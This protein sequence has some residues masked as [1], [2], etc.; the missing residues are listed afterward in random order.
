MSARQRVDQ[1]PGFVLH[2]YPYRET[3]LIVEVFSRDFGRI[4][5]VAKGARRPM[6]QLRGVL[7][8]FQ[9]LLID[10]SGGGEMKTLVRAEW[11]G[12]QPLLGGQ[13]LLCAYY[14]NELLM[15]LMPREDSHPE[16]HRAY[17]EA[18]RALAANESQEVVLRRFELA[19]LQE[20]GYGLCLDADADGVPVR[21]D[22]HYAYIIERGAVSLDEY[23]IDDPS[24]VSG[25]TLLD[26][27]C[28]DFRDPE[29]LA[30]SKAL[31]RR[32]IQH[33]LGGQVLQSR[34]VFTELFAFPGDPS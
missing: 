23:G 8:A 34:R 29:A 26:M 33:Y 25:K 19:L 32:L 12:G 30:Q 15:R 16:L 24:V 5:L 2:S 10:W 3:S 11:L 27:A 31:M 21:P 9:P 22:G 1:Q 6:S 7:M 28:G 13:A 18:L 14:A 17:G 20:L 4:G